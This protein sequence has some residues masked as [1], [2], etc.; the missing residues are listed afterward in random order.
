MPRASMTDG[1]RLVRAA[2]SGREAVERA[3]RFMLRGVTGGN[4]PRS[5][6]IRPGA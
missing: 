2:D 5:A 1:R 6:G 3:M 4:P